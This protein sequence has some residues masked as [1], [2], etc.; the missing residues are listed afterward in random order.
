MRTPELLLATTLLAEGCCMPMLGEQKPLEEKAPSSLSASVEGYSTTFAVPSQVDALEAEAVRKVSGALKDTIGC[1]G[2]YFYRV[3]GGAYR[4]NPISNKEDLVLLSD[5]EQCVG[6]KGSD[7]M[8]TGVALQYS[9]GAMV[10]GFTVSGLCL[11]PEAK[12]VPQAELDSLISS[13][14]YQKDLNLT[15]ILAERTVYEQ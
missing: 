4:E 15:T 10:N 14:G 11:P 12:D 6:Q 7:G 5:K 3:D 9:Q 1:E 2:P 8:C 13:E